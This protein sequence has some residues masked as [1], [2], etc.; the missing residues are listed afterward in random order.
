[1]PVTIKGLPPLSRPI[2][3]K[4]RKSRYTLSMGAC[5]VS[6]TD[7]EGIQHAVEVEA[8]SLYEAVALA[9]AEFRKDEMNTVGAAGPMTEF[10]VTAYRKPLEHRIRLGQVLKWSEPTTKEGPAGITKRERVRALLGHTV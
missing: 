6:F 8:D 5:R 9:V 3:N 7:S 1:M 4:R 2:A 10:I